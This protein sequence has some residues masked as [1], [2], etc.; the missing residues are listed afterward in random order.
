MRCST[1]TCSATIS[2][3][4]WPNSWLLKRTFRHCAEISGL[5]ERRHPGQEKTGRQVTVSADLIYDVLSAHEPDHILLQATWADAATGLL[6]VRRLGH[7]G[8]HQAPHR[9]S[10]SRRASRRSPCRSCWRSA[11]SRSRARR[12]TLPRRSGGR[13]TGPR[14]AGIAGGA[15]PSLGSAEAA[16]GSR[17]A[18]SGAATRFRHGH[19]PTRLLKAPTAAIGLSAQRI[20][21]HIDSLEITR[22][23]SIYKYSVVTFS[24]ASPEFCL[25]LWNDGGGSPLAHRACGTRRC[26]STSSIQK[27]APMT[28][29]YI[30]TLL[31]GTAITSF[32]YA[33]QNGA[34]NATAMQDGAGAAEPGPERPGRRGGRSQRPRGSRQRAR[35]ERHGRPGAAECRREAG[36]AADHRASSRRRR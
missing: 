6:D 15:A 32:A 11:A 28:K 22:L 7:A 35:A 27:G 26:R 20:R 14:R 18:R 13:G 23:V 24:L 25:F 3:P 30:A 4:G 33:Q 1:R 10:G 12:A 36:P 34:D 31:A 2:T 16:T 8:A 17:M 19:S 29:L 9:P 5:I 21:R